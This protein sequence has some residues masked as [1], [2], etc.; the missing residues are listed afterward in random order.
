M[1]SLKH[2]SYGWS[3]I[4]QEISG[5]F[6]LPWLFYRFHAQFGETSDV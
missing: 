1:E 2:K 4:E 5:R 3:V 6:L